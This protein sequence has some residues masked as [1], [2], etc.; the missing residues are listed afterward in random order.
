MQ[1]RL[2]GDADKHENDCEQPNSMGTELTGFRR[3]TVSLT[4][5]VP[6]LAVEAIE[7]MLSSD[8]LAAA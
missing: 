1:H 6:C 5:L 3:L 8:V 4:L 7:F 2:N